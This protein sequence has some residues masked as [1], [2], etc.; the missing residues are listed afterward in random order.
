[1]EKEQE[2]ADEVDQE[3]LAFEAGGQSYA[4]TIT[5]V[6]EIRG[7]TEPSG[8]PDAEP[9]ILGVINL[10]GEFL[11]LI[12]L[13]AKLGLNTP[14]IDERSVV[15][16]VEVAE[17]TVGLLVDSVSN[18]ITSNAQDMQPPPEVAKGHAPSYVSALTLVDDKTLRILDLSAVLQT[19]PTDLPMAV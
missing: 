2:L 19:S 8:M 9:H 3:Y 16:L 15:I 7:W 18:I 10:R 14:N 17:A 5:A 1:M 6:R 11:P 13:A 12:D 4:V